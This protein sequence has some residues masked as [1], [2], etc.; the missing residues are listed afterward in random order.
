MSVAPDRILGDWGT[1][2]LRLMLCAGAAVVATVAG[3]GLAPLLADGRRPAAVF[4]EATAAWRAMHG[5]LPALL[6][7]MVG[8]NLG[9]SDAGY[10]ETPADAAA[11]TAALH[12]VA[13]SEA[14]VALVPGVA[15]TGL[16]G[17]PDVMRGEETQVVGALD[18]V[19]ALARGE[20]LLCLPGT[21]SK[22]VRLEA[23]RI[24]AFQTVLTGESFGL[25]AAH[26][27]LLR[28]APTDAPDA[29]GFAAGV[30]RIVACGAAALPALLFETRALQ[31]RAGLAPHQAPAFLSGLLIGAE[32]A[33]AL[34]AVPTALPV[35]LVGAPALL[36]LYRQACAAFGRE[37]AVIDGDAA[38]LAGLARLGRAWP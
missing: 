3:P 26:G 4:A 5:P 9:W 13:D 20:Q 7:G 22:W 8:A 24:T 21:H 35:T 1:S 28:G 33:W 38:V 11:L 23:G 15:G 18:L 27:L 31:L 30:A 14:P 37:V 6:C 36:P 12:R 2:R 29:A 17:G 19:P 32:C 10:V 34:A 25:H 16:L